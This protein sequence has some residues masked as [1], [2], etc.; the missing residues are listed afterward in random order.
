M[1]K[2]LGIQ[3]TAHRFEVTFPPGPL[4]VDIGVRN[5]M[6]VVS[7][8]RNCDKKFPLLV[9]DIIVSVNNK[10]MAKYEGDTKKFADVITGW[11]ASSRKVVILRYTTK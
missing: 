9:N 2:P 1:T 4:N 3:A 6:C 8:V 5:M 10:S 11:G 7:Q